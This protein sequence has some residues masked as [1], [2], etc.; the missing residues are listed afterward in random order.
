MHLATSSHSTE[1]SQPPPRERYRRRPL[2]SC[3]V[4]RDVVE[5]LQ[6]APAS[7]LTVLEIIGSDLAL[8]KR[9]VSELGDHLPDDTVVGRIEE[10]R[11]GIVIPRMN[12]EEVVSILNTF[13]GAKDFPTAAFK[14]WSTDPDDALGGSVFAMYVKPTPFWKRIMDVIGASVILT[15]ATPILIAA[16]VA[17]KSTCRGPVLFKQARIGKGGRPF[18]MYKL[19]TMRVD[20]EELR[21][22]LEVRNESSGLAFKIKDDPRVFPIGRLLRKLSIDELPQLWNVLK[23]EMSL[24]GPRPLPAMDWKPTVS[25]HCRRHDVLPGLTGIWQ[26]SGRSEVD[27]DAWVEMDLEYIRHQS[28]PMDCTLLLKTIPAVFSRNGAA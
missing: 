11:L 28:L 1:L 24:V 9:L 2:V 4:F 15:I 21:A 20:A 7:G 19:R 25:W 23:G 17:I 13:D 8:S 18:Q 5:V 12:A 27:F 26:V 14:I 10:N 6:L 22:E 3:E 16:S